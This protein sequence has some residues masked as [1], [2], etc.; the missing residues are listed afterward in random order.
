[1]E[2]LIKQINLRVKGTEMFWNDPAGAEAILQIRSAS[3]C[4]DGRFDDYLR[5]AP[6]TAGPAD[7]P[8][9]P[10]HSLTWTQRMPRNDR[11]AMNPAQQKDR[12]LS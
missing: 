10:P 6:V 9:Q 2:S 3:L 8:P 1:M 4:E 5:A 7:Q 11:D 12:P